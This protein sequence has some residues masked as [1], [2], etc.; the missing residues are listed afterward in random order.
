MADD[1]TLSFSEV[2]MGLAPATISPFVIRKIGEG[3]AREVFLT[4][5]AISA[6]RALEIGLASKVVPGESLD[7]AVEEF[8]TTL[9]TCGPEAQ[10]ATKELLREVPSMPLDSAKNFT[11]DRIAARRVAEEG[12]EG[13]AAFLERRKPK[14]ANAPRD[15]P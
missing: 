5:M 4:G 15:V 8:Y 7:A 11:A 13:M 2:R 9:L 1:A 14:W 3:R 12:Q 6:A 10:S